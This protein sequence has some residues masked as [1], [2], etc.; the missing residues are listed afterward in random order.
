MW[1]R[2]RPRKLQF[3]VVPAASAVVTG[4]YMAAWTPGF[5]DL[6]D[7]ISAVRKAATYPVSSQSHISVP[8]TLVVPVGGQYLPAQR[9]LYVDTREEEDS[10]HGKVYV[11][12]TSSVGNYSGSFALTIHLDWSFE[13]SGAE[14]RGGN[15]DESIY[16]APGWNSYFTDSNNSWKSGKYVGLKMHEGGEFVPF[17]DARPGVVYELDSKAK[18]ML[19]RADG[20]D[21]K[22]GYAVVIHDYRVDGDPCFTVFPRTAEGKSWAEKYSKGDDEN[23]LYSFAKA[24]EVIEPSNPA[25]KPLTEARKRISL[26]RAG[27]GASSSTGGTH[28]FH[29]PALSRAMSNISLATKASTFVEVKEEMIQEESG[30]Q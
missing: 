18:L 7:G 3:R 4:S 28:P 16:A 23:Y 15:V 26:T 10:L 1:S 19:P 13:F 17:P 20:T 8:Q 12:L 27:L 14:L 25:W 5:D 29:P 6:R 24:G 11:L 2:W 21:V 22:V 9:W 30:E